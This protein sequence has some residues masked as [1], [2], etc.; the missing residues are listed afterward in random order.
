MR[1]SASSIRSSLS[2]DSELPLW[3]KKEVSHAK[4]GNRRRR[5]AAPPKWRA[6]SRNPSP[7]A[8]KARCPGEIPLHYP[9]VRQEHEATLGFF[10]LYDL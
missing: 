7:T 2:L 9:A 5:S 4:R 8:E 6:A 10:V 1:S 3:I